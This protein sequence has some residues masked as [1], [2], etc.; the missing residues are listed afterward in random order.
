M[1]HA[2]DCCWRRRP[3]KVAF[4]MGGD[5]KAPRV[6]RGQVFRYVTRFTGG[7]PPF[8]SFFGFRSFAGVAGFL[9]LETDLLLIT[10]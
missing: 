5:K 10:F 4:I 2:F 6:K 7:L 1:A 8:G 3:V 9:S